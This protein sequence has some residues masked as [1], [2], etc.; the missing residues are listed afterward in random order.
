[1]SLALLALTSGLGNESHRKAP[2]IV[3]AGLEIEALALSEA[4]LAVL[5]AGA[6]VA[7]GEAMLNAIEDSESRLNGILTGIQIASEGLTSREAAIVASQINAYNATTI[8]QLQVKFPSNESFSGA[9]RS[10]T[11]RLGNEVVVQAAKDLG[12]WL[13]EQLIALIETVQKWLTAVFGGA[14]R[15]K[16]YAEKL[17]ELADSVE[18]KDDKRKISIPTTILALGATAPNAA[19]VGTVAGKAKDML[20]KMTKETELVEKY[21]EAALKAAEA[22]PAKIEDETK[23]G[24]AFNNALTDF[25]TAPSPL[26]IG[27]AIGGKYVA[28]ANENRTLAAVT[29]KQKKDSVEI[30]IIAPAA[31]KGILE[32]AIKVAEM[33]IDSRKKYGDKSKLADEIKKAGDSVSKSTGDS[34][35]KA[36][37]KTAYRLV[38][39]ALTKVSKAS[40]KGV[41]QDFAAHALT[42]CNA[43]VKVCANSLK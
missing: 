42:V 6:E 5:E 23:D 7:L 29:E 41:A 15:L 38:T 26:A 18:I 19:G 39:S 31:C 2:V 25:Q 13:K 22:E 3:A 8:P 17:L 4:N 40:V 11:T 36:E 28:T 12:K 43:A 30:V 16:A 20:G 24:S 34:D 14:E 37:Q 35:T 21:M 1:M 27:E 32:D 33:V 9:S 10:A